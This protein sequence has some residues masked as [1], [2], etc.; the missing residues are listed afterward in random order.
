MAGQGEN[1]AQRARIPVVPM[2]IVNVNIAKEHELLMGGD[3]IYVL[4]NGELVSITGALKEKI[5]E[6]RDGSAVIHICTELTLPPI[7]DRQE[8]HWYL[9]VLEAEDLLDSSSVDI[10]TY[11][12]YG[13]VKADLIFNRDL[14]LLAQNMADSSNNEIVVNINMLEAYKACFYIPATKSPAFKDGNGAI[15]EFI[16]QDEGIF[17]LTPDNMTI[18]YYVY[19]SKENGLGNI[20]ITVSF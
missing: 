19:S 7:Q 14:L 12:Y 5:E 10:D 6:I 1:K 2:D 16:R 17:V 3:D 18:M 15:I 20:A 13:V 9:V 4:K 11:I 8:N